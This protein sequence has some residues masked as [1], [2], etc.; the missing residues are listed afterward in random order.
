MT[1]T[2]PL[3]RGKVAIVD[4][5]DYDWLSQW[6]WYFNPRNTNAEQGYAARTVNYKAD[7]EWRFYRVLMHRQI[8]G[9]PDRLQADHINGDG[10]DNRRANLRLA[11]RNENA[12]N[13]GKKP[14]R[15]GRRPSKYKGLEY[16]PK[17]GRWI[18]RVLVG[19]KRIYLGTFDTE[20][21]AARAY[22]EG[23]KEHHGEYAR[24]NFPKEA[25]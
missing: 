6:K 1:K 25:Q 13:V 12:R 4:D 23:A 24:L 10:T 2:I 9:V 16:V 17:T 5:A 18:A 22:D 19:G 7:G 14:D 21:G 3:T 8:L 11:T 15:G 20:L